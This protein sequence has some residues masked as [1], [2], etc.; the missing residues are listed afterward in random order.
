MRTLR[1]V[2]ADEQRSMLEA[3]RG[4]LAQLADI[5]IV[6]WTSEGHEVLPLVAR[7]QPDAVLLDFRMAG[8]GGLASLDVLG[9]QHPEVTVLVVSDVD[10]PA[11]IRAAMRRGASA[12]LPKPVDL[13]GLADSLREAVAGTFDAHTALT[14]E[15]APARLSPKERDVLRLVA[16]GLSNREIARQLWISEATVKFHLT[17]VFRKLGVSNRTAAA[18]AALRHGLAEPYENSRST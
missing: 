15:R 12:Y 8:L 1:V 7:E 16:H 11:L 18:G 9:K 2:V 14:R 6:A 13:D 5:R 3:L 10:D 4:A 17:N